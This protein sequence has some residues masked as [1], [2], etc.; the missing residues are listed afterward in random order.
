LH[1]EPK[2]WRWLESRRGDARID[3]QEPPR[4]QIGP[5]ALIFSMSGTIA[6]DRIEHV[7]TGGF[8][9]WTV[10][11]RKPHNDMMRSQ[12]Q[13][14]ELRT[15]MRSLL[16]T[17][18]ARHGQTTRLHVFMAMPVSAAVELGRVRMPKADMPWR[19]YDQSN[20]RGGFVRA[21]DLG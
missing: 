3:V 2:T 8:V 4:R 18:K 9:P 11:T 1:R 20:Q 15:K 19:L 7:L 5:P 17:I 14:V 13:L 12:R 10:T 16:D 6:R 21:I